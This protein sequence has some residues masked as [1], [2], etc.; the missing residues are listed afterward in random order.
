MSDQQP[1]GT[2]PCRR[3]GAPKV[4]RKQCKECR[5]NTIRRGAAAE[6]TCTRCG[7]ARYLYQECR[8]CKIDR[9]RKVGS[10]GLTE[11][12][13]PTQRKERATL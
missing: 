8:P 4:V 13:T 1:A 11:A 12:T 7:A 6:V 10:F 2:I 5:L 9:G 3:C